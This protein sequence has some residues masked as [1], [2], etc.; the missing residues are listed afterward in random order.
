MP[1]YALSLV[2]SASEPLNQEIWQRARFNDLSW[3]GS[4]R[5]SGSREER[6]GMLLVWRCDHPDP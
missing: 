3:N 1:K 4:T 6:S 2:T 5:G